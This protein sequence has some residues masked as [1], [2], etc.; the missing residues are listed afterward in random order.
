MT[1][2][3]QFPRETVS[4]VS[5]QSQCFLDFRLVKT[6]GFTI[7]KQLFPSGTVIKSLLFYF[8]KSKPS[9]SQK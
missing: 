1:P 3:P 4:F 2:L 8:K 7:G 9:F 6:V 5:L